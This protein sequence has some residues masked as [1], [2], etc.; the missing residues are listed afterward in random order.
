MSGAVALLRRHPVA[1]GVSAALILYALAG[2]FLAPWLVRRELVA[3]ARD[4]L[5]RLAEVQRIEIN[6]F[7]L[8]YR[9]QGFRLKD[10]DDSNLIGL[11]DLIVNFK[12][13]PHPPRLEAFVNLITKIVTSPFRLLGSLLGIESEDLGRMSDFSPGAAMSFHPRKRS[14]RAS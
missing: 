3:F 10:K 1:I 2:F 14:W 4:Q 5:G 7:A 6:P 9:L 12:A 13:E 8:S 11:D